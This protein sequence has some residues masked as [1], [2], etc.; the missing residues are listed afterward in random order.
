MDDDREAIRQ[1]HAAL[2]AEGVIAPLADDPGETRA[3][4]D[5]EIASLVEGRFFSTLDPRAMTP[6]LRARWEPRATVDGEP[7]SSP[8]GQGYFRAAHWLLDGGERAGTIGLGTWYMGPGLVTVSS[9]YVWP[10]HR[11]RGVAGRALLRAREAFCAHGGRGLRVPAYWTWQPA[12][13][14]YL[15]LGLWVDDWKQ[16]I[17]FRWDPASPP[18]RIEVGEREARFAIVWRN[19]AVEPLIEASREGDRLGWQELPALHALRD[20]E[21]IFH[22]TDT[23]AVALAVHGWPL[24][25]ADTSRD[26]RHRYAGSGYPEALAGQIEIFEAHDRRCGFEVRTPRIPGLVYREYDEIAG[27]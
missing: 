24:L 6:E 14:F 17:V 1:A 10:S 27:G 23:F 3:W 9:L 19:G 4:L 16:A 7:L 20:E 2:V 18:H 12:V 8:H 15:G 21:R 25:R 11:G 5:C 13:R 22:A 26:D